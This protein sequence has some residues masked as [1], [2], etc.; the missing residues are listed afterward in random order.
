MSSSERTF[1]F[2]VAFNPRLER[3]AK[4]IIYHQALRELGWQ[5]QKERNHKST[6]A[7]LFVEV[8]FRPRKRVNVI[9]ENFGID[10]ASNS[11][12]YPSILSDALT[13]WLDFWWTFVSKLLPIPIGVVINYLRAESELI[14]ALSSLPMPKRLECFIAFNLSVLHN[15]LDI[16]ILIKRINSRAQYSVDVDSDK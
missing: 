9:K 3:K 12:V 2:L 10:S 6:F 13:C 14:F 11:D 16:H 5:M 15:N 4:D 1:N 8:I 7:V